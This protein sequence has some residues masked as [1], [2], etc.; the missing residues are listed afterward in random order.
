M[1]ADCFEAA[2]D[3]FTPMFVAVAVELLAFFSAVKYFAAIR[4][5]N[6]QRT[7][8]GADVDHD[9]DDADLEDAAKHDASPHDDGIPKVF[10]SLS[11]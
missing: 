8:G 2:G 7:P 4:E 3:L 11:S 6:E 10:S 1:C 9:D 5:S